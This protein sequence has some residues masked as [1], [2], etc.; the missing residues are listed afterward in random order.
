MGEAQPS[1]SLP[2]VRGDAAPWWPGGEAGPTPHSPPLWSTAPYP[3]T[4]CL[5]PWPAPRTP[6]S[7][8]AESAT[9]DLSPMSANPSPPC[10]SASH[11]HPG[12]LCSQRSLRPHGSKEILRHHEPDYS[13][14]L[15]QTQGFPT[16]LRVRPT[17][18]CGPRLPTF[19]TSPPLPLHPP[20][21]LASWLPHL[22]AF[23]P[24]VPLP[25]TSFSGAS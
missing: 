14:L 5:C 8:S 7:R 11:P 17:L 15:I 25:G 23:A 9:R 13:A 12:L 22:R 21:T 18:P 2:V 19:L 1:R 10:L 24:A 4:P 3:Q 6:A 20:S 16:P